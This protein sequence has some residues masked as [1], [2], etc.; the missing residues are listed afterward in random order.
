MFCFSRELLDVNEQNEF[1]NVVRDVNTII[2]RHSLPWDHEYIQCR[3]QNSLYAIANKLPYSPAICWEK[4]PE[5]ISNVNAF[6]SALQE[7]ER[8]EGQEQQQQNDETDEDASIQYYPPDHKYAEEIYVP[9]LKRR[10]DLVYVFKF[11][12]S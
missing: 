10:P 2:D 11:S 9:P 3:L 8:L 5:H 12:S 6:E 7:V 4:I 1:S